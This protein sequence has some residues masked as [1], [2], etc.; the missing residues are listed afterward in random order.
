LYSFLQY[1]A[2]TNQFNANTR[3]N[4]IHRPLSDLFVVYN[5]RRDTSGAL[6]ERGLIVKFT[7]MFDF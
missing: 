6:I 3:F 5:E 4:L 1:K 7:N 2:T